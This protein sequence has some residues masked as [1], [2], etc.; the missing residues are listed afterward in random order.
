MSL[1]VS[2]DVRLDTADRT[3]SRL[4]SSGGRLRGCVGVSCFL[5]RDDEEVE[6]EEEWE[7]REEEEEEEADV[8]EDSDGEGPK[9]ALATT[10]CREEG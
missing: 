6:E 10:W 5:R 3:E 9:S 4:R 8:E 1:S 7:G 2:I